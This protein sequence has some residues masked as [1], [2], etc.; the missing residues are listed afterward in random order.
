MLDLEGPEIW[1]AVGDQIPSFI[2]S[3]VRSIMLPFKLCPVCLDPSQFKQG[4]TTFEIGVSLGATNPRVLHTT[5]TNL[6][7]QL[8][9]KNP[10]IACAFMT[11]GSWLT[12][13]P[14]RRLFTVNITTNQ[15]RDY[16]TPP[17]SRR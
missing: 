10:D 5:I 4:S 16:L 9:S 14:R 11:P 6:L 7:G 8:S 12:F 13:T 17:S 2:L 3:T 1:A 15:I